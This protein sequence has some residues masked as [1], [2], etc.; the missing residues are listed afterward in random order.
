MVCVEALGTCLS[1]SCVSGSEDCVNGRLGLCKEDGV[2]WE[3]TDCEATDEVCD[4]VGGGELDPDFACVAQTCVPESVVC[5]ADGLS[6][7]HCNL[8]GTYA[9]PMRCGVDQECKDGGCVNV[10]GGCPTAVITVATVVEGGQIG[11]QTVLRLSGE[12]SL[13]AV[14]E[15][16]QYEWTVIQPA[17]STSVF[18]PTSSS[19]EVMFEANVVGEYVFKL[20]VRDSTGQKS[21]VA[22]IYTVLV[23]P[24]AGI[25][26]ELTWD[27]PGDADQTDTGRDRFGEPTGSDVDLH[28][29]HPLAEGKVFHAT[30]DAFTFN[31]SPDWGVVGP[32]NNPKVVRVDDDGAG[33]EVV[34]LESPESDAA[35]TV[36]AHYWNEWGFGPSRVTVRIYIDGVM[37]YEESGI[38]L[39]NEELWEIATIAWPS[40]VTTPIRVDGQPKIAY[41]PYGLER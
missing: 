31:E 40:K 22:S 16:A 15:V 33:P 32:T 34:V 28:F 18:M 39:V 27:T 17:G 11:P 7:T 29:L 14:G 2:S 36:A 23:V 20:Y 3:V 35:Y 9:G 6:V 37:T 26:I 38:E 25:R 21:C 4:H 13:S 24:V 8:G 10:P 5:G 30:Y 12:E 41:T 1:P 19:P